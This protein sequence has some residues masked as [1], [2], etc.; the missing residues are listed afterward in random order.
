MAEQDLECDLVMRGGITSGVVYPGVV[1]EL[2]KTYRFRSIGGTSAGALAAAITAAAEYGRRQGLAD[3]FDQ[4]A[5]IPTEL[6]EKVGSQPRLLSLFQA[7][8]ATRPLFRLLLAL[9]AGSAA[10][11]KRDRSRF[12]HLLGLAFALLKGFALR[13]FLT[14]AATAVFFLALLAGLR[15]VSGVAVDE[16]S[17]DAAFLLL[18]LILLSIG[19]A[20][21]GALWGAVGCA[22]K[23]LPGNYYG[24]CTGL[25]SGSEPA[26]TD[27]LHER[28]QNLAGRSKGDAPLTFADLHAAPGRPDG[29]E[30]IK[31]VLITSN[32][33]QG[34]S[35]SF[36]ALEGGGA[37]LFFKASEMAQFLPAGVVRHLQDLGSR[38]S[39]GRFFTDA[40]RAALAQEGLYP[41]PDG[42]DLPILL[43]A[44]MSLSFP[45]LLSAVPL[46]VVRGDRSSPSEHR[47]Q[48]VWFSDGGLTTNFPIHLFDGPLPRRPT[49]AINLVYEDAAFVEVEDDDSADEEPA[50]DAVGSLTGKQ[51]D[52]MARIWM[53]D[54]N[55]GG[56]T[57]RYVEFAKSG[58]SGLALLGA[59]FMALFDTAR[60]WGDTQL[61]LHPGFRDRIVTIR[62]FPG[63]G[64]MN[65]KMPPEDIEN[66]S[67]RGEMAGQLLAARFAGTTGG[68]DP[69]SGKPI[70]LT[71]NNHRWVRFRAFMAA[72]ERTL[73]QLDK[74]WRTGKPPEDFD[75]LLASSATTPPSYAWG[76][77]TQFENSKARV[78]ALLAVAASTPCFDPPGRGRGGAPRPPLQLRPMP[79]TDAL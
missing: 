59:F 72:H 66:L 14:G 5:K 35:H 16:F 37:P 12:M 63:E 43:A 25:G 77:Q 10:D 45:F 8:A 67:L 32:I 71:W 51:A 65:L 28:I 56:R 54:G 29:E 4:V 27:W 33:T 60:N 15:L 57:A 70:R 78:E 26:L 41:L 53:P 3:S 30:A 9:L 20:V 24:L 49:F 47:S 48:P 42:V 31:L 7:Q 17:P 75:T 79:R 11:A 52:A 34:T 38:R 36:P 64:G 62:M 73:Q 6:G 39:L 19:A 61:A 13:A 21:L 40:R 68:I 18:L 46:Y 1:H 23:A 55:G 50:G 69:Q 2:S 74:A 58:K 44:R 76:S 22:A